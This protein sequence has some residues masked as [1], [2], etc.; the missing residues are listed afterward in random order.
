MYLTRKLSLKIGYYAIT[1]PFT[2]IPI[3]DEKITTIDRFLAPAP[4]GD[5]KITF[6][7]I[8]SDE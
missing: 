1:N 4:F 3:T 5:T 8:C 2:V 6:G 7:V